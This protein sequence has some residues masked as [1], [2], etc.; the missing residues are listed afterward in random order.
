[1]NK[2]Y[3]KFYI[4][5][6]D[7]P[8][9]RIC[10]NG[11]IK[12]IKNM[13]NI[14][15][16]IK[17]CKK[18]GHIINE[19]CVIKDDVLLITHDYEEYKSNKK[20]LQV[21][22]EI[23]PEMKVSRKNK[24]KGK[25]IVA[26]T[27]AALIAVLALKSTGSGDTNIPTEP[28]TS[29]EQT[30]TEQK[31]E[32]KFF[33]N[34]TIIY[35]TET[36]S[37]DTGMGYELKEGEDIVDQ[38]DIGNGATVN[39]IG[40][41]SLNKADV[42]NKEGREALS[43]ML[44]SDEFHYTCDRPAYEECIENA[45]RYDDIFEEMANRYGVDKEYLKAQACQETGGEHYGNLGDQP[46]WGIMQIERSANLGST[47]YGYNF[48]TEE[49]ESIE[50]TEE[51]LKDVRT[52]IQIGTMI[53]QDCFYQSEYNILYG[54]TRYNMGAGNM[55]SII[56]TCCE[57]ENLS[58]DEALDSKTNPIWLKY[59]DAAGC[60]DEEYVEHVFRFLPN[61]HTIKIRNIKTGEYETLSVYND[62]QKEKEY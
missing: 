4:D 5:E 33:G 53:A 32:T 17:I 42:Q 3:I 2:G 21:V 43:S 57:R 10:K 9:V 31:D 16:L 62:Y 35:S 52:N 34:Q 1:M 26:S 28:T 30:T 27:I 47:I 15:E 55:R 13:S 58:Q 40:D 61:G 56:R 14:R 22:G 37:P 41:A 51:N 24:I 36:H 7:K 18:Y 20:K 44:E 54:V 50:I 19:E 6:D 45:N 29:Y 8:A 25:V 48:E 12:K 59:R 49:W 39:I 11:Q 60:G 46:A 23:K 38:V